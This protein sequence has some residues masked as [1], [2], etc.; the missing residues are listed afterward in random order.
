MGSIFASVADQTM[1][2]LAHLATS[3][4]DMSAPPNDATVTG[5]L[6][7]LRE[8]VLLGALNVLAVA[9]PAVAVLIVVQSLRH[10]D[11][12]L[13]TIVLSAYTLAFPLLRV[14]RSR[15]GFRAAALMLL[16]LL[17]LTAFFIYSR[18]GVAVGSVVLSLL[19]VFLAALF[20]GRRG[21]MLGLLSVVSVVA[22]AGFIVV[23]GYVP[24]SLHPMWDPNR[25][26]FWIRETLA[27]GLCGLAIAVTQTYIVERLIS[28]AQALRLLA[29]REYRQRLE[30][31]RAER[32]RE[33]E[34]EQRKM[35]QQAL[36]ES[37]RIEALA[38]LSGGIAHDFNNALTVI[39]GAAEMLKWGESE[40]AEVKEFGEEIMG[41][42]Q[43]AA[44]L[45]R[46]LLTLGRRH[47]STPAP[48]NMSVLLARLQA[49]GQRVVPSD[50]SFHVEVQENDIKAYADPVELERA[51][52]NLVLNAN[53]AM[54]RGGQLKIIC[55]RQTLLESDERLPGGRYVVLSISDEGQGMDAATL[56]RIF[57]P[58]F[59]TK[60]PSVGTG[61][62][63]ATVH[64]FVKSAGGDIR[65]T[66]SP[67][68][69]TTFTLFLPEH[70]SVAEERLSPPTPSAEYTREAGRR[71]LVVE[72]QPEV[73]SN[74]VRIL[75]GGGF[76]T[77]DVADGDQA[78][79]TLHTSPDFA[80]MCI[81]GVMPG[82]E[83]ATVLERAEALSPE[84]RVL[85]CSGYIKED[86]V[87]RGIAL[88][89]Y[90]Y[91]PKPFTSQQL[92]ARVHALLSPPVPLDTVSR[93][94]SAEGA[95]ARQM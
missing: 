15:L 1:K 65:V 46:Q 17:L 80:L 49:A 89:K 68:R 79:E 59:T 28:E 37:R 30:L 21:A 55:R 69:G 95:P 88:G 39:M 29:D 33:H 42:A 67:G 52:L 75:T 84:M 9:V 38:R 12:G 41:A 44:N 76:E 47:V 26:R 35:A 81:D 85:I 64:A 32:E 43:G 20:F 5:G 57:E 40:P 62:G 19:V 13:D 87:R 6:G 70:V 74:I 72:D 63:L 36:E 2:D 22:I 93:Q 90:S 71:V 86:L 66:S 3:S 48:V 25:G 78:L 92:L 45:T 54:P 94:W 61:L 50:I 56:E 73:R 24:P 23:S 58:F 16:G 7:V 27:L 4:I 8:R 77:L 14:A 34:R 31:E 82:T 60:G 91:L 83:T 18:G 51:L 53:D 11:L 10:D